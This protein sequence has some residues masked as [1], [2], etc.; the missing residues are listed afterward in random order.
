VSNRVLV[1]KRA[2]VVSAARACSIYSYAISDSILCQV[3]CYLT[4]HTI[5][6]SIGAWGKSKNPSGC[7]SVSV[8]AINGFRETWTL[9]RNDAPA[10]KARIGTGPGKRK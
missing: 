8:A 10:A 3:K 4:E 2:L 5:S 1:F 7:G 9:S 6:D